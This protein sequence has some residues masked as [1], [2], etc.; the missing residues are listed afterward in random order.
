[1]PSIH[2]RM[3][4]LSVRLYKNISRRTI[5]GQSSVSTRYENKD[6]FIDLTPFLGD[7]S[8]VTTQKSVR[9]PA[10]AFS[11]T[12]TD[13]AHSSLTAASQMGSAFSLESIYGLVEPMDVVE[14]RMWGGLGDVP[15]VLPIK[16][17]G[18]VSK[19]DRTMAMGDNGAPVRN[20]VVSGQ[21][22]GKIWQ[23]F[24][25]VYLA[26]YAEGLAMLTAFN[27]WELFG[28]EAQNTMRSADLAIGRPRPTSSA[29]W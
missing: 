13:S 28:V 24:Q 14:I 25:I 15:A 17:R 29:P 21:D 23:T 1:M 8:S 2:D 26:A 5:D 12:F 11:I 27:L 19:I 10:G 18:F 6:P 16:M 9:D 20:V 22:Y 4:R 7:G 3:P